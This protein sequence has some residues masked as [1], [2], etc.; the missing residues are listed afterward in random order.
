[1]ITT[2]SL[3]PSVDRTV[4]VEGFRYGELNRATSVHEDAGGKGIN[5]AL[6]VSQL[7]LDSECIGFMYKDSAF[8]FERKLIA[9]GTA[10]AFVWRDG[11]AR[12]NVKILDEASGIITEINEAGQSVTPELL[13]EMTQLVLNHAE[14]SDYL[15]LAGSLPP[16]CPADY[17]AQLIRAVEG[18]GCRCVLDA[19]GERLKLGVQAKPFLIKPNRRELEMIAGKTLPTL[20]DIR[21]AALHYIDQGISVVAVSLGDKG[22]LIT[23]GHESLYAPRMEIA[24]KTTVGAGDSMLAGLVGGFLGEHPLEECFRM[25]VACASAKCLTEGAKIFER[26]DYRAMYEKVRVEKVGP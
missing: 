21:D 23:D 12:T 7:G 26:A 5:V 14:D 22:A 13:D 8:I 20:K 24:A 3:N 2:I 15:I 18:L 25:G 9:N 4:R 16:Q 11:V 17:Y 10:Y 1:M 6:S 19:D